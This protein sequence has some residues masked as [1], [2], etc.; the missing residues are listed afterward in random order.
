[1]NDSANAT[2][3]NGRLLWTALVAASALLIIG[4]KAIYD[5]PDDVR[6]R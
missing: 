4:V 2:R 6:Y 1:M 3:D 5:V